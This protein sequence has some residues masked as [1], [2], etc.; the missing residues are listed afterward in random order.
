MVAQSKCLF[1]GNVFNSKMEEQDNP[2]FGFTREQKKNVDLVGLP[3]RIEHDSTLSVGTI[4]K[5]WYCQRTNRRWVIG[6]IALDDFKGKYAAHGIHKK[7][8]TGLSLQHL[9]IP[10]EDGEHL[11]LP[12]EVSI[13]V[14]PRR[15][16]CNIVHS[17]SRRSTEIP[18][19]LGTPSSYNSIFQKASGFIMPV[20]EKPVPASESSEP[21]G[22]SGPSGPSEGTKEGDEF[23]PE[24]AELC[25]LVLRLQK[26]NDALQLEKNKV[27][28]KL[29]EIQAMNASALEKQQNAE[30]GK[31]MKMCSTVFKWCEDNGIELTPHVVSSLETLAQDHPSLGN[32]ALELTH[33]ASLKYKE[34]QTAQLQKEISEKRARVGE[35]YKKAVTA[36]VASRGAVTIVDPPVATRLS[37][38]SV[39]EGTERSHA[40]KRQSPSDVYKQKNED[41]LRAFKRSRCSSA[42]ESMGELYTSLKNRY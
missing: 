16:K 12:V 28:S 14:D 34:L 42:R 24:Q 41:L 9:A 20:V 32:I 29:E 27:I 31:A 36:H 17:A 35:V 5:S 23:F 22:P 13:V 39:Y 37:S 40:V 11:M 2:G 3:I 26:D 8:F 30:R 7:H 21:S 38:N 33:K 4:R 10:L 18:A 1:I 15:E 6:D 25:D 19:Y